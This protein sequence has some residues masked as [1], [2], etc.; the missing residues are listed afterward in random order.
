MA[1]FSVEKFIGNGI[2]KGLLQKL[3]EEGWDDVPTL[4]IMSSEEMDLLHMTQQQK[5][6]FIRNRFKKD[7]IGI[8]SYV[9]DRSLMQYADK[10]EDCG[11]NLSELINLSTTDLST[12][13]EMKRGHTAR[14][15][16]RRISD[17]SFKLHALAARRKSSIM[18]HRDDS[19]PK[20]FGSNSSNS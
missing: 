6:Q 5:R 11:K 17:D 2:L 20:S 13:F 19:I 18:M 3:L 10:M 15:V 16:N 1:S 7:A 4:K 9:H 8:R 14:F 12:Q